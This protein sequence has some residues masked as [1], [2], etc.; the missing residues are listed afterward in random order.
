MPRNMSTTGHEDVR[1]SVPLVLSADDFRRI[2][3]ELVDT[4]AEFLATLP[5]RPV[6]RGE[7]PDVIR[8]LLHADAHIPEEGVDPAALMRS[9][10]R[11]L[12]DHSLFNGHPRF[13]GYI[14]SSPAH[15]G[16]LGDLLAAAVNPNVHSWR[17]SPVATE[18]EAQ[19]VRWI[20]EMVGYPAGG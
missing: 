7:S 1:T 13:F 10:A 15:I 5:E 8:E 11:L 4:I 19:T 12:F 20:A 17:L 9:T 16:I 3:H 14:T 2:G 6:T 18:I